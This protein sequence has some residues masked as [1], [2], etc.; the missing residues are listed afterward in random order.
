MIPTK[1]HEQTG[2]M[3]D[4]LNEREREIFSPLATFSDSA[5]RRIKDSRVENG[6]RQN[7]SVD[8]DRILNS[9]AYTRYIDKTQVFSLIKNDHLT[10]RVLHVQLVSRIARTIGRYLGLNEDLIE[11]A[12]M[13]HDLGHPPFGHD[14]EKILSGLTHKYG[15]GYFHH[16]VQSIQILE[17]IEKKGRGWNLSLQTLDAILCHNGELPASA[18]KPARDKFVKYSEYSD[19][20]DI[21]FENLDKTICKMKLTEKLD[22]LSK[23][24]ALPMTMEGCVVRISD[25]IAYI[26]RDIEDS[27]RLNLIKRDELPVSCANLLGNT[28]GTIV[29]NLVTDIIVTSL[30]QPFISFSDEISHAL[31]DL[32]SF[33]YERIYGNPAIKKHIKSVQKIYTYLFE[34]FLNDLETNNLRSILYRNFLGGLSENYLQN[35]SNVEIVRDFISGMTDSFFIAQAPESL[36][37]SSI[38]V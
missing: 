26:G 20:H 19:L 8:A 23:S 1:S 27:I 25:T 15:A 3:R 21:V 4:I 36:H 34:S 22:H 30:R 5:I 32:K 10:H 35:H 6:Y 28:N 18:I 9:L 11:A 13:G 29:Y 31:N 33:N 24:D 14:G 12:S 2:W 38:R 16:N 37:P 17:K 7:F